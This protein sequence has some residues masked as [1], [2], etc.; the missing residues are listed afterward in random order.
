[1]QVIASP[2]WITRDEAINL[3]RKEIGCS[4]EKAVELLDQFTA[5]KPEASITIDLIP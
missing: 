4:E 3:I 1:M 2:P 5:E